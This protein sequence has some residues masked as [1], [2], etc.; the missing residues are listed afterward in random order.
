M[1]SPRSVFA[2][3][4]AGALLA[5]AVGPTSVLGKGDSDHSGHAKKK[6]LASFKDAEFEKPKWGAADGRFC[7]YTMVYCHGEELENYGLQIVAVNDTGSVYK[8]KAGD[9]A[10]LS[11]LEE[12]TCSVFAITSKNA[13]KKNLMKHGFET[14]GDRP[15]HN[16]HDDDDDDKDH[17][18]WDHEEW[19]HEGHDDHDDWEH[20]QGDLMDQWHVLLELVTDDSDEAVSN[21]VEYVE[22][23]VDTIADGSSVEDIVTELSAL[24]T[25]NE[26]AMMQYLWDFDI[27]PPAEAETYDEL[28]ELTDHEGRV[29]GKLHW[30]VKDEEAFNDDD[31]YMSGSKRGGDKHDDDDDHHR[32]G[33]KLDCLHWILI[34]VSSLLTVV[35]A[36]AVT[37]LVVR[38]RNSSDVKVLTA[39]PVTQVRS[40]SM[41]QE[42]E[43]PSTKLDVFN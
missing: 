37:L 11:E 33:K 4:A 36:V 28:T 26:D 31:Y 15:E 43:I 12:A 3:A 20:E 40:P 18:E 38:R 2:A 34:G 19:D 41:K 9:I 42:V 27:V 35:S 5:L 23:F 6:W 16:K 30:T 14:V 24:A 1:V 39:L 17:G 32:R 8:M 22:K 29:H 21:L 25:V 10:T 7:N 13:L